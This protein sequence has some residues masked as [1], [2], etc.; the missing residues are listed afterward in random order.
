M[1]PKFKRYRYQD[2]RLYDVILYDGYN[3]DDIVNFLD[4][5]FIKHTCAESYIDQSN[6]DHKT[7][8]DIK[9]DINDDIINVYLFP[10]RYLLYD[11]GKK[12]IDTC[13]PETLYKNFKEV[14]DIDDDKDTI[15]E[16]PKDDKTNSYIT[17]LGT[18]YSLCRVSSDHRNG[19][20]KVLGVCDRNLKVIYV[21]DTNTI[22][23]FK[24]K[25]ADWRFREEQHSLH[26][27]IVHAY[28]T[29]C[30]LNSCVKNTVVPWSE[31]EEIVDWIAFMNRKISASFDEADMWLSDLFKQ[32]SNKNLKKTSPDNK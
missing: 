5:R 3:K 25:D 24:N 22:E 1:K 28:F 26:H 10:Y 30:G 8:I 23:S 19:F 2:G 9:I 27:E 17:I 15:I 16:S 12:H 4:E 11:I 20:D 29:E 6:G 7:Y 13:E 14:S 21:I 31:D 18:D 32:E